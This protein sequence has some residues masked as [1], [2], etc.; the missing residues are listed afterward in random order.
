LSPKN[1][2]HRDAVTERLRRC[3]DDEM[4][5]YATLAYCSS[6]IRFTKG[7]IG[8]ELWPEFY[9]LKAIEIIR[10]RLQKPD[11]VDGWLILSI[12]ALSVSEM[13][14]NNHEASAAHL[15]IIR[16]FVAQVG[17][18]HNLEPYVME[19]LIIGDKQLTLCL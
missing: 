9:I 5:M 8:E 2:R 11:P 12:Y 7:D 14:A 4:V 19:G 3:I 1:F 16:Y 10:G 18:I 17:G 15:K 13:W 6:S